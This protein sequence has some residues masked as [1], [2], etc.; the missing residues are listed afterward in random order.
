MTVPGVVQCMSASHSIIHSLGHR[1][2]LVARAGY[3]KQTNRDLR[4]TVVNSVRRCRSN[5]N[6]D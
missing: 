2:M 6:K 5:E 3:L 4:F 1:L